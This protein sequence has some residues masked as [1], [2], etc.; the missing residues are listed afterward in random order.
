MKR[1]SVIGDG[2]WGTA[3]AILLNSKGLDVTLWSAFPEY[4]DFMK[5]KR[6]NTKFLKGVDLPESIRVTA[7]IQAVSGANVV[8]FA[9]PSEYLRKVA[10]KFRGIELGNIVSATK[11]IENGT[12]K[13]ASEVLSEYFPGKEVSVLSGPSISGEVAK[14]MPTAVVLASEGEKCEDIR[15]VLMTESFRVYTSR[16]VL[17]VELG[18][19]VKNVIAIAAG[20]S[21]GLGFGTNTKAGLLTRGLAELTRLGMKMGAENETFRG[22]SGLGD[23]ATTCISAQSRNRWFGEELG[24]GRK[25]SEIKAGT[26]MAIEGEKT[27][28]SVFQLSEKY[29]VDM[30]ISRKVYEIIYKNADPIQAV[31]E[32]MTRSAK[33]EDY[34]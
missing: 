14:G 23:L 6:E 13:R 30:P 31:R 20:M 4:A 21:D 24:K 9:V 27:S 33:R 1:I 10:D 8:F 19:A 15:P 22:L 32:L 25:V 7:D 28:L 18:G 29:D 26:E 2:G 16:D 5:A 17:G 34:C 12:L 3:L 11:G